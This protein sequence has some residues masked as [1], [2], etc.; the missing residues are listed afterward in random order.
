MVKLLD[1]V[2]G[3]DELEVILNKVGVDLEDVT[4]SFELL[5]RFKL[6]I[7]FNEKKV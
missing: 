7:E 1:K 5:D 4:E 3:H 2:R 6:A